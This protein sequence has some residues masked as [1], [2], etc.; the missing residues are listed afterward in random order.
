MEEVIEF[1][2]EYVTASL[3]VSS[4]LQFSS[5]AKTFG[6]TDMMN[7]IDRFI[8]WNFR[9]IS[10]EPA[11]L[12]L[13]ADQLMKIVTSENLRVKREETVY[14]AVWQWFK[15]DRDDR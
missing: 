12:Q 7:K 2:V 14:E 15:H 6:F 11:F 9:S 4:C 13:S 8:N 1:L 3:Q 5:M 10:K